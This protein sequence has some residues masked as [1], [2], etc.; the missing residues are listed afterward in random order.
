MTKTNDRRSRRGLWG[1]ALSVH[2]ARI[3]HDVRLWARDPA[4]VADMHLRRANPVPPDITIPNAV[5]AHDSFAA[6]RG[7]T[8]VVSATR[9][10]SCVM[11]MAAGFIEPNPRRQRHQGLEPETMLRIS[12]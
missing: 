3:G 7:A 5:D 11:Q 1:T 9:T 12:K 10:A 2:L 8:I 4:L 6:L